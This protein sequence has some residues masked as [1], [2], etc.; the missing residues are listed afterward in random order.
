MSNP[1]GSAMALC[2]STSPPQST[3]VNP[4]VMPGLMNISRMDNLTIDS[5]HLTTLPTELLQQVASHL[6]A[7]SILALRTL[8]QAAA[9]KTFPNFVATCLHSLTVQK[10]KVGVK[11]VLQYLQILGTSKAITHVTFTSPPTTDGLKSTSL[12]SIPSQAELKALLTQLPN[13][14]SVTIREGTV[15]GLMSFNIACLLANMSTPLTE[16]TLD[17]CDIPGS[18]VLRLLTAHSATL[19]YVALR[20]VHILT[21]TVPL[22]RILTMLLIDCSL[23][24]LV[25]DSLSEGDKKTVA[26][27]GLQ[28]LNALRAPANYI[29]RAWTSKSGEPQQYTMAAHLASMTGTG[30]VRFGLRGIVT[31]RF[32]TP[33]H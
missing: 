1:S 29:T 5:D 12:A 20:N 19:R 16:L 21:K 10:T 18:T 14:T 31:G 24:R 3:S 26:L 22:K 2:N 15:H 11:Q 30:G 28:A 27:I 25:L 6:S 9:T 17:G 7:H 32:M 23:N 33:A 13:A 4:T 8:N